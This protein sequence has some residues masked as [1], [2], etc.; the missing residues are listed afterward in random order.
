MLRVKTQ[1]E[2]EVRSLYNNLQAAVRGS[3]TNLLP[4]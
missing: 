3:H 2:I 4:L 1:T